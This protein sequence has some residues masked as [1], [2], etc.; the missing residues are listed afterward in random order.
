M[1][2][3]S[4]PPAWT[5]LCCPD[6]IPPFL[7]VSEDFRSLQQPTL[8][9]PLHASG[10]CLFFCPC[11]LLGQTC[12]DDPVWC[13]SCSCGCSCLNSQLF[14]N[15]VTCYCEK[16]GCEENLL[17]VGGA[18]PISQSSTGFYSCREPVVVTEASSG[19]PSGLSQRLSA[20]S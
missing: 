11:S 6:P 20:V 18:F 3:G 8:F 10:S 7:P 19:Q 1:L 12:T 15:Q 13:V 17:A 4:P 16:N 9:L 5:V 2:W 14:R